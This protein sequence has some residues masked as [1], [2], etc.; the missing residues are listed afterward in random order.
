MKE[1][2]LLRGGLTRFMEEERAPD[3]WTV[4]RS[5]SQRWF[6]FIL[7][8]RRGRTSD[9]AR[10]DTVTDDGEWNVLECERFDWVKG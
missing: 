8:Q 1:S 3:S 10:H 7:G 4:V 2:S 6:D 9:G 5:L